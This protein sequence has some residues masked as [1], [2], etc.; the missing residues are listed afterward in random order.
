MGRPYHVY[1]HDGEYLGSFATWDAAHD[2]AHLQ[3][4]LGGV[5]APL[6]IEDRRNH[7][8]RR[9][10]AERCEFVLW[11]QSRQE[12]DMEDIGGC[13]AGGPSILASVPPRQ[14]RPT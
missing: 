14:R 9:L 4:A 13:V 3:A 7:V 11:Q 10:W 5:L 2:W 6:E 12:H 1:D 8:G